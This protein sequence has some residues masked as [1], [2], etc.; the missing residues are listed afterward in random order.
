MDEVLFLYLV[1]QLTNAL[2][3]GMWSTDIVIP[4]EE[5]FYLLELCNQSNVRCYPFILG[6][7]SVCYKYYDQE[8]EPE[9]D[10]CYIDGYDSDCN[11]YLRVILEWD[12]DN[13]IDFISDNDDEEV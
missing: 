2:Q 9:V 7:N 5:Y 10:Y 8:E 13:K 12:E 11:D 4:K 6:F 1:N 3:N